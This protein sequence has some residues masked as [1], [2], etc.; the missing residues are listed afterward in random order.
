[1]LYLSS[2]HSKNSCL[3]HQGPVKGIQCSQPAHFRPSQTATRSHTVR[4]CSRAAAVPPAQLKAVKALLSQHSQLLQ[5]PQTTTGSSVS[6]SRTITPSP[7][8]LLCR[9]SAAHRLCGEHTVLRT[10]LWPTLGTHHF[11]FRAQDTQLPEPDVKRRTLERAIL[12]PDHD[13]IDASRKRCLV[14]AFVQLL[15]RNQ[16]LTSKLSYVVHS[17]RLR[18]RRKTKKRV[19]RFLKH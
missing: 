6:H 15:H 18:E 8:K 2:R 19:N 5:S 3:Q 16:D 13:D 12:L 1:M 4:L 17:L 9:T 10:L 14:N 11:F 7:E